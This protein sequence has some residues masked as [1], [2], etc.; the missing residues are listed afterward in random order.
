[1]NIILLDSKI[2]YLDGNWVTMG[3][4]KYNLISSCVIL[5][6]QPCVRSN[7]DPNREISGRVF[8]TLLSLASAVDLF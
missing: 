6:L 8:P 5:G 1:M 3:K 2:Y 7:P 4:K